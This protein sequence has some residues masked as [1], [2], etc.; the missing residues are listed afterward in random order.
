MVDRVAGIVFEETSS[1]GLRYRFEPRIKV[2]RESR[3]V[4]TKW[5]TVTVKIGTIAG[6]TV[7]VSPEFRDCK[8]VAERETVPLKRVY[9]EARAAAKEMLERNKT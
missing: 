7:S 9:E 2:S 1:F 4:Q 3:E 8:R 6:K 5:G